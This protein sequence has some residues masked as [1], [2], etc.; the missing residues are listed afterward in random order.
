[1][2]NTK[3]KVVFPN[4]F[5]QENRSADAQ[6]SALE[7]KVCRTDTE[8]AAEGKTG[9][10]A[11][12]FGAGACGAGADTGQNRQVKGRSVSGIRFFQYLS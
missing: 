5:G 7:T 6:G 11:F 2:Q 4:R 8:T 10:K 12:R 3:K 9:S 1:M